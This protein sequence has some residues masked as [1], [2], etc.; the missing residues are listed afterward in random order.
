[1]GQ[2]EEVQLLR[3]GR[4]EVGRHHDVGRGRDE[5]QDLDVRAAHREEGGGRPA[6]E[7]HH[8]GGQDRREDPA[9][10]MRPRPIRGLGRNRPFGR[11]GRIAG[12]CRP[13]HGSGGGMAGSDGCGDSGGWGSMI[14]VLLTSSTGRPTGSRPRVA[15]S[16]NRIGRKP[17]ADS[18]REG[19]RTRR[20]TSARRPERQVTTP[21]PGPSGTAIVPSGASTN[22][23]VRSS[24]K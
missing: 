24:A 12:R 17:G 7:E 5:A 4:V 13:D 19:P 18:A 22:G 9:T 8:G 6:P 20:V 16:R 11:Q 2:P 15:Q 21:I 1:M 14:G 10:T 23:S 3:R